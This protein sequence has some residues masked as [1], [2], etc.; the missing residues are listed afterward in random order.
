MREIAM[1]DPEQLL[2]EVCGRMVFHFTDVMSFVDVGKTG[3]MSAFDERL[4]DFKALFGRIFSGDDFRDFEGLLTPDVVEEMSHH[5]AKRELS[6]FERSVKAAAIV[7]AH[8]ILDGTAIDLCR[9]RSL[10]SPES[11]EQYIARKTVEVKVIKTTP[12]KEIRQKEIFDYV[13]RKLER[14]TS[15]KSRCFASD[16]SS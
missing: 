1:I 7:F 10:V 5:G 9:V 13:E 12:Y 2:H 11:F 15:N 8:S 14:A 16:V 6:N 4:N 3:V